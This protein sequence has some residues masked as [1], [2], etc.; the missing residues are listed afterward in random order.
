MLPV[1]TGIIL[2]ALKA[3]T[4]VIILIAKIIVKIILTI[5]KLFSVALVYAA[6]GAVL[7][8]AWDFNPFAGGLYPTLYLIGFGFSVILS[9]V[10]AHR[11]STKE[12]RKKKKEKLKASEKEAKLAEENYAKESRK[13][14]QLSEESRLE[15]ERRRDE[16][17]Q[18]ELEREE[19]VKAEEQRLYEV[20]AER[21]L[22][23]RLRDQMAQRPFDSGFINY[24]SRRN[25]SGYGNTLNLVEDSY[26]DGYSPVRSNSDDYL[27]SLSKSYGNLND[28]FVQN[29]GY[30]L[31]PRKQAEEPKIY[32]SAIEPNTLIHEYSD[33]FEVYVLEGG[34][35]TLDRVEYKEA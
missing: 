30:D 10:I 16:L 22:E 19:R 26:D 34:V 5:G 20:R 28:G 23:E 7:N 31:T 6:F 11:I 15:Y 17:K 1:Q 27:G 12:R 33:R 4:E 24:E 9:F 29:S 8:L 14:K 21:K 3:I 25:G 2:G 18:E 13:F 32:M 35:K